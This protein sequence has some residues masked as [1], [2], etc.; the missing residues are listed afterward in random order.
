MVSILG[1]TWL[2]ASG[3]RSKSQL[4][5]PDAK[6]EDAALVAA[7]AMTAGVTDGLVEGTDEPSEQTDETFIVWLLRDRHP[8]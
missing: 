5:V 2:R 1:L 4:I 7:T 3:L 6:T 8:V